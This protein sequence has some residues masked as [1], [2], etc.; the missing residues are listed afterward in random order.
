MELLKKKVTPE[1]LGVFAAVFVMKHSVEIVDERNVELITEEN[2]DISVGILIELAAIHSLA[3]IDFIKAVNWTEEQQVVFIQS[4]FPTIF[5][6]FGL[7]IPEEKEEE[8]EEGECREEFLVA[9]SEM[10]FSR[11]SQYQ[12]ILSNEEENQATVNIKFHQA[13]LNNIA[14]E[15]A[16][17]VF[18]CLDVER[19]Y[20]NIV[21]DLHAVFADYDI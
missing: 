7:A 2:N 10:L 11:I 19:L 21:T 14:E 12:T 5:E 9:T 3:T 15:N 13:A 4:M 16:N 1:E 6:A 17:I 20:E 18:E 8:G